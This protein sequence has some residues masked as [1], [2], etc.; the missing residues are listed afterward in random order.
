MLPLVVS[1]LTAACTPVRWMPPFTVAT[2][3]FTEFGT[4]SVKLTV[5]PWR[6]SVFG[7][8]A[9][10]LTL[11]APASSRISTLPR[12]S[13][14][15]SSV[16][17]RAVI[18]AFTSTAAPSVASTRDRAVGVDDLD[19]GVGARQRVAARPRV[20]SALAWPPSIC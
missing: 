11:D 13:L 6:P 18:V 12:A 14:A 3:T 1:A 5:T 7:Y 4:F 2:S 8:R 10:S 16:P 17:P 15:A 20:C 19:A 9:S